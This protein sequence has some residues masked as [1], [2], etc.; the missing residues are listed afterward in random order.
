[1]SEEELLRQSLRAFLQHFHDGSLTNVT[2][3]HSSTEPEEALRQFLE[4]ARARIRE[5]EV[6]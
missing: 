4:F 6:M 3:S 2:E 1:M 5:G